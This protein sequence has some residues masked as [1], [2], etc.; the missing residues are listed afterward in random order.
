MKSI[1][2]KFGGFTEREEGKKEMNTY[3]HLLDI[4]VTLH[5]V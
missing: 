4:L 5:T 1:R 2:V 3:W